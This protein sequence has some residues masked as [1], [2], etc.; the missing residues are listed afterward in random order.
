VARTLPKN[1]RLKM[2]DIL[3]L[4]IVAIGALVFQN[5]LH[6]KE[7]KSLLNRIM[8]RDYEQLNYYDT[9]FKGEVKELREQRDEV[10]KEYKEDA[11]DKKGEDK[12]YEKEKAFIEGTDEDWSEEEVDLEELRKKIPIEG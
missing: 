11:E 5:W 4:G 7:R 8:A 3:I 2:Y 6:I 1:K 10:K 12:E 9:M